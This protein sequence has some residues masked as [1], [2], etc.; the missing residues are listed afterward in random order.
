MF[1]YSFAVIIQ[2]QMSKNKPEKCY[3]L[4]V[5][6]R[7][8]VG[9]EQEESLESLSVF[10]NCLC[11][12]LNTK[13]T[14]AC[15]LELFNLCSAPITNNPRIDMNIFYF[16]K[17]LWYCPKLLVR[18]KYQ[19]LRRLGRI[20]KLLNLMQTL[21]SQCFLLLLLRFKSIVTK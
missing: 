15:L 4:T 7:W 6:G 1:L 20:K 13:V 5:V 17:S 12:I 18:R 10:N 9:R 2:H 16:E 11:R 19:Y 14:S 3:L 8:G 21:L